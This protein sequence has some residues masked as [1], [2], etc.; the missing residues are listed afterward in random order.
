[1]R[2]WKRGLSGLTSWKGLRRISRIGLVAGGAALAALLGMGTWLWSRQLSGMPDPT[3]E[4]IV[5][6][7]VLPVCTDPS[8]PPFEYVN[9]DTGQIE[10]YDIELASLIAGRIA[11]AI[12]VQIVPVGFDGLYDALATGRCDMVLSALPYDPTRTKD[13]AYSIA[14]FNA[15]LVLAINEDETSIQRL[16]D[17]KDRLVGVEWGFVPEGDGRQRAFLR[18]LKVRR[19]DTAEEALRALQAREVEAVLVDRIAALTYQRDHAGVRIVGEPIHDLN[20][21]IAVRRDSFRLLQAVDHALLTMR[22]DG[23]LKALEERW[24]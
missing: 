23:T 4:Q 8:W 10:G 22:E 20:Y 16:A 9:E 17:L 19:Y 15:G 13:V 5:R 12:S 24:F 1:M 11:P 6:T 14:Y 3:W 7:G 21:V 18:S 2:G